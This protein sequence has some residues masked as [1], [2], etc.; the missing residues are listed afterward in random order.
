[1]NTIEL[2]QALSIDGMYNITIICPYDMEIPETE[3]IHKYSI[4]FS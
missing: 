4:E 1:M 3:F 2:A